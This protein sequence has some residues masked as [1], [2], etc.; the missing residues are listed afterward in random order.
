MTT[1]RLQIRASSISHSPVRPGV[2][3]VPHGT[4]EVPVKGLIV[5]EKVDGGLDVPLSQRVVLE[6]SRD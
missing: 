1:Y 4:G 5:D 2:L 6:I 3:D